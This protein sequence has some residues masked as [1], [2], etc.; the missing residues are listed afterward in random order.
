M[1]KRFLI[2]AEQTT[3]QEQQKLQ[4]GKSYVTVV[5]KA[6]I[7]DT[8]FSGEKT[9]NSSDYFYKR[10]NLG[11]ETAEGNIVYGEQMGGNSPSMNYKIKVRNKPVDGKQGEKVEI[12]WADRLNESIV[13]SVSDFDVFKVGLIREGDEPAEG[14]E[15]TRKLVVKKFLSSY[16]AHDYIQEHLKD[17][18]MIM[19]K[20]KYSFQ[21][22]DDDKKKF[23]I[24]DIFLSKSTEGFANFVQTILLDEDSISKDA[25]KASKETGEVVISARAVDYVSKIK[26]KK[27]GKNMTFDFPVVV[28]VNEENPE[29]TQ[30][31]LSKLFK[32]KK[33][34]IREI[35]IEGQIFEG[36]D[37]KQI[38][39]KDIQLSDDVKQ[40]IAMNLYSAEDAKKL[41][42]VRG[43][44]VSKM[45]FTRPYIIKDKDDATKV[46]MDFS[47]DKYVPEDLYVPM[48]E[49]EKETGDSEINLTDIAEETSN[50]QGDGWLKGLGL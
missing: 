4:K 6:K 37:Q 18:M 35:T 1:R 40:L 26:G 11:I 8:T 5:G 2:M 15:D 28:K 27:V 13:E 14:E 42:T 30:T 24:K 20:G 16:D 32:V 3:Q 10:L 46:K 36:Y 17:G 29:I 23:E 19:A 12:E 47:D 34:K 41:L 43:N 21:K 50:N 48:P 9:S 22:F 49:E 7:T 33:G 25:L 39:D 38:S 45:L 44:K 31:I